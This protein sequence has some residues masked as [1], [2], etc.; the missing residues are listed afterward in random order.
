MTYQVAELIEIGTAEEMIRGPIFP[1]QVQD[2]LNEFY[3]PLGSE[4]E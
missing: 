1:F 2:E 4:L 3:R